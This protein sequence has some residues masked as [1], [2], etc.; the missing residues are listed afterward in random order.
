MKKIILASLFAASGIYAD[1]QLNKPL[2]HITLA[3]NQGGYVNGKPWDSSMLK[4]KTTMLMYVDPDEKGKG[5]AFKPTIEMLEKKMNFKKFQILV[6]LNLKATWKPSAL[7]KKL[8]KGKLSDYPKRIYVFD[9]DTVLVNKWGLKN[10]AYNTLVIDT[11]MKPIYSHTG[12]WKEGE[13]TKIYHLIQN[14]AK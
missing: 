7:I 10:D 2:P 6:I 14:H 13:I 3:S 4:G 1:V 9:N 12:T 8:T 5:E 11:Q